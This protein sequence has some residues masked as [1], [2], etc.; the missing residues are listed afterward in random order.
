MTDVDIAI[1]QP[2]ELPSS[3]KHKSNQDENLLQFS[4][5]PNKQYKKMVVE[6][7]DNYD[8]RF[9]LNCKSTSASYNFKS[10]C[11][12]AANLQKAMATVEDEVSFYFTREE[13]KQ[14]K[15]TLD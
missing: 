2:R 7:Q 11:S 14:K 4:L 15:F 3:T 9:A 8:D 1:L 13:L 5:S 6:N 10:V 12:N